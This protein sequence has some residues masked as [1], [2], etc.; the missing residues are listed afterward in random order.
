MVMEHLAGATSR[1]LSSSTARSRSSDAV[2]YVLQA[3]EAIAEAHARGIV[4]RDLKPSNLFLTRRDRRRA[5]RQGA[6]LRD[7]EDLRSS[8]S[9]PRAESDG[10][11]VVMG[12]PG[13]MSP[14]QVRSAKAVDP[15]SDIWSLGV[16]LY[17]L[18]TGVAPFAGETVGDTFARIVS[19]DP[20]PIRQHR[21]D[22]S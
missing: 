17:E 16:I 5:A 14:E 8:G 9:T 2:D 1:S 21:P 11:G 10:D 22:G 7:L 12:S 15:R 4:H 18:L 19:E 20:D 6:R 13:Y 3:C